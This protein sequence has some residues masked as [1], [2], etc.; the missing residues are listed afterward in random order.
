MMKGA[1][2]AIIDL[3]EADD[4]LRKTRRQYKGTTMVLT[5][6][7]SL[8]VDPWAVIWLDDQEE[9]CMLNLLTPPVQGEKMTM[10]TGTYDGETVKNLVAFNDDY[11]SVR[12]PR[13]PKESPV[14]N[15]VD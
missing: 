4:L 1:D 3:V 5:C 10:F 2:Q 12:P 9:A 15:S 7:W 14:E 13:K 11:C 6:P 8:I